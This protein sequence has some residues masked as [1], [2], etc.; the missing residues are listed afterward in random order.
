MLISAINLDCSPCQ[1]NQV[2][3]RVHQLFG[4]RHSSKY[5]ILCSAEE[6]NSYRFKTTWVGQVE[7]NKDEKMMTEFV[8]FKWTTFNSMCL[9]LHSWLVPALSVAN[10][11]AA[12]PCRTNF[13]FD[14]CNT[15]PKTLGQ[16]PNKSEKIIQISLSN[17]F[18]TVHNATMRRWIGNYWGYHVWV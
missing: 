13:D 3:N 10:N 2:N 5:H 1:N 9:Q 18:E 15:P 12:Q 8:F 16:R 11:L 7:T 14:G 17:Y 6:R 4:Y